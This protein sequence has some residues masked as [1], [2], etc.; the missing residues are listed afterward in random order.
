[1]LEITYGICALLVKLA[2][3]LLLARIFGASSRFN[4]VAHYFSALLVLY[5]TIITFIKIFSCTPIRR[6][7]YPTL[8]GTCLNNELIIYLDAIMAMVT[9]L[10]VILLPIPVVWKLNMKTSRKVTIT[11]TFAV[12]SL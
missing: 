4:L 7:W 11:A 2:V 12:G 1:M 10:I 8:P 6:L 5:Y 9:D 3:L